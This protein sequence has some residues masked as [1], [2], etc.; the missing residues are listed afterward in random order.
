M[1]QLAINNR[2]NS[3]SGLSPF[4]LLHGYHAEPIQQKSDSNTTSKST[5]AKQVEKFVNRLREAQ[6]HASS[7]MAAAQIQ[8]EEQANKKRSQA[9]KFMVGEKV[10]LNLKNIPSPQPKKISMG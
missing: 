7:A 4:F 1:A 3:G 9:P 5:S 2:D 6:D 10:W 8:M